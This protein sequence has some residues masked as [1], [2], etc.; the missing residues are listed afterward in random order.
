MLRRQ[1]EFID[2][3]STNALLK[4]DNVSMNPS[5]GA[6]EAMARPISMQRRQELALAAFEAIRVRGVYGITM[7]ELAELLGMK[8][9][10]LYWYFR[11]VGHVFE[12]VL[13]HLLEQQRGFLEARL[14]GG[15][16]QAESRHPCDLLR[17][18]AEGIWA[19]FEKEG[20]LVLSLV[21]F[22]GQSEGGE[23]TRVL[24]IVNR[25]FLPLVSFAVAALEH[26][27]RQGTVAPCDPRAVVDLVAAVIDG[28]LVHRVTRGIPF[29]P[30]AKLLWES[31]LAP[32][33]RDTQGTS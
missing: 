22:W 30:V 7:S 32:L 10:T 16:S 26:G 8:R 17:A 23:P 28:S 19:F 33:K 6:Q 9:P 31:V 18:Y 21:S 14:V 11:D 3:V 13:E 4:P 2:T 20:P 24:E 27:I 29:E 15:G 5:G 1:D 12:T 25:H